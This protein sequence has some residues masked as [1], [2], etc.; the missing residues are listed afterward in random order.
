MINIGFTGDFCPWL[1]VE[2]QFNK[3]NWENIFESV[4]PFFKSISVQRNT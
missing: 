4:L 1:R 2:E 3:D